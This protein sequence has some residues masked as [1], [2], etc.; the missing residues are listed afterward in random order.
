MLQQYF[1]SRKASVR[2]Y[3]DIN[4]FR[5]EI[6]AIKNILSHQYHGLLDL[7]KLLFKSPSKIDAEV[8]GF[9][10]SRELSLRQQT[11]SRM[12]DQVQQR[13][14]NF[15]ELQKQADKIQSLVSMPSTLTVEPGNL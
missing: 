15:T 5:E 2:T 1:V 12:G 3:D 9:Y 7:A 13:L 14:D 6:E 8:G 11:T 4:R 10:P